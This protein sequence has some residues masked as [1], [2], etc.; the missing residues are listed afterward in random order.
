MAIAVATVTPAR[1]ASTP[2]ANETRS[3]RAL[4][5]GGPLLFRGDRAQERAGIVVMPDHGR[6]VVAIGLQGD[7]L[8]VHVEIDVVNRPVPQLALTEAGLQPRIFLSR[9][10]EPGGGL[11]D[12]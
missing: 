8:L 4:P 5:A 12:R 7:R 6:Q 10:E 2:A 3:S 9:G 11:V 1:T